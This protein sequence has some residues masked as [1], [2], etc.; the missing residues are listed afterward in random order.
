MKK[1]VSS[2]ALILCVFSL[3]LFAQTKTKKKNPPVKAKVT[4]K[5][6]LSPDFEK[7]T[8]ENSNV[9]REFNSDRYGFWITFPSETDNVSSENI[10]KFASFQTSTKKAQYGLAVKEL[11]VSLNNSQLEVLFENIIKETEDE[12]TKLIGKKDVYLNGVLGKELIYEEDNKIVFGRFYIL[13]SKLFMLTV[14]VPKKDYNKNFDKWAN[15]F[16]DSFG[17]KANVRMDA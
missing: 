9:W 5:T 10:E 15:K 8:E 16:F 1:I 7:F 4:V 13:E 14:S 2:C 12:T 6:N 17:V 3:T 11:L